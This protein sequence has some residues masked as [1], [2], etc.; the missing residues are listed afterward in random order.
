MVDAGSSEVG[1][2]VLHSVPGPGDEVTFGWRSFEAY[3]ILTEVPSRKR[4]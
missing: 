3:P 1:G 4:C 2:Q